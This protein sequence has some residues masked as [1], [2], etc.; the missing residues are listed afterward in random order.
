L[1]QEKEEAIEQHQVAKQEKYDLQ[2]NF[3]EDRAQIQKEK[4]QLLVEQVGVK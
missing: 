2:T 1:K 3:T 4:E